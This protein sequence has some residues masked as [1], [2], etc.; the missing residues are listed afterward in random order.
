MSW[1][2]KVFV[3]LYCNKLKLVDDSMLV[4][5]LPGI[6]KMEDTVV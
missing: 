6:D 1:L 5:F 2:S 3:T 4:S